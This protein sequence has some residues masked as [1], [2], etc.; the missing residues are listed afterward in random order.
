MGEAA[1]L[2]LCAL[3]LTMIGM[4]AQLYWQAVSQPVAT[5]WQSVV[6]IRANYLGAGDLVILLFMVHQ[7]HR[8]QMRSFKTMQHAGIPWPYFSLVM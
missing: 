8:L 1:L 2:Q 4:A 6:C 3:S 5:D 7:A